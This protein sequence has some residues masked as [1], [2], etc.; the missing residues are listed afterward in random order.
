MLAV[1]PIGVSFNSW[2]IQERS[3]SLMRVAT[4]DGH[5]FDEE[6]LTF[7]AEEGGR[8]GDIVTHTPEQEAFVARL[9]TQI[10]GRQFA[11]DCMAGDAFAVTAWPRQL[12]ALTLSYLPWYHTATTTPR[13][14]AASAATNKGSEQVVLFKSRSTSRRARAN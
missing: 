9:R 13:A 3:S 10:E 14:A 2:P 5:E 1:A 6:L 8:M 4:R 7:L 11:L 12:V